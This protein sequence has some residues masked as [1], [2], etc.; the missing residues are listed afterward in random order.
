MRFFLEIS[1]LGTAY[2]GWQRQPDAPSIQGEIERY[3]SQLLD[4]ETEIVGAGRTDAGVHCLQTFAHFDAPDDM[5]DQLAYRLNKML[6]G[7]IAIHRV[8][9]VADDAHARYD[10]TTRSYAYRVHFTKDPFLADRSYYFPFD[11]PDL[12]LMNEA[13]QLLLSFK[14]FLPLSKHNPDNQTT[15]CEIYRATWETLAGS[16]GLVFHISANRFLWNMVRRTVG[17]LLAI[18]QGKVSLEEFQAGMQSGESQWTNLTAPPEGL[19]LAK[20]EYPFLTD[21]D[22]E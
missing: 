7:D 22:A 2:S 17:V 11:G 10:A 15:Q 13:A 19:Y 18:G 9:Q 3:L 1:Y 12:D 5:P 14:D 20:V 21:E 8:I 6:P 4:R 16:N